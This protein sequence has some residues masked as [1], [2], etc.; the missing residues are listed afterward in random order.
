MEH[1]LGWGGAWPASQAPPRFF[2][3]CTM[4]SRFRPSASA[5]YPSA[6]KTSSPPRC[7]SN[8]A[9][10]NNTSVILS[11]GARNLTASYVAEGPRGCPHNRSSPYLSAD[12]KPALPPGRYLREGRRPA[13]SQPRASP[14]VEQPPQTPPL[15]RRPERSPERSRRAE[16]LHCLPTRRHQI[17]HLPR[18]LV[19]AIII[20]RAEPVRERRP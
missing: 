11:E 7:W 1:R 2:C 12:N 17:S 15:C 9:Q 5:H 16:R 19:C 4:I 6:S 20:Y 14:W 18:P 10:L 8:V 3:G 13:L